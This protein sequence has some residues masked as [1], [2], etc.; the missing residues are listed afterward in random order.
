MK[1]S[2]GF[3]RQTEGAAAGALRGS[4]AACCRGAPTCTH[5][6]HCPPAWRTPAA[7]SPRAPACRRRGGRGGKRE[8]GAQGALVR[9]PC[10]RAPARPAAGTGRNR[11]TA[12]A[13]APAR[14][15]SEPTAAGLRLGRR[16]PWNPSARFALSPPNPALR[17]PPPPARPPHPQHARRRVLGGGVARKRRP[18][19]V[20]RGLDQVLP[21]VHQLGQLGLHHLVG[22]CTC[23][24]S[25]GVR[26]RRLKGRAHDQLLRCGS[27]TAPHA[28]QI[29]LKHCARTSLGVCAAPLPRQTIPP[30][31]RLTRHA[32]QLAPPRHLA[33]M[34][35]HLHA[36][37]KR[38]RPEPRPPPTP[39]P[40]CRPA[41][42][43]P[44]SCVSARSSSSWQT[45]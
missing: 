43:R 40:A 41:C 39:H 14:S 37:S 17:A 25:S 38:G 8:A 27:L 18:Q 16:L 19:V 36:A 32:G 31:L 45:P 10:T 13:P 12:Q 5:S 30:S 22:A 26:R 23:P 44:T 6:S 11:T 21:A 3:P 9:G 15:P 28:P 33:C 42:A 7:R 29:C 4:R 1:L 20:G 34:R 35:R 2:W 24:G